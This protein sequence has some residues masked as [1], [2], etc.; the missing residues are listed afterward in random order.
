M[1]FNDHRQQLLRDLHLL[2]LIRNKIDK[3][4]LIIRVNFHLTGVIK[5]LI[6]AKTSKMKQQ[7]SFNN[8]YKS[9]K[10]LE[11]PIKMRSIMAESLSKKKNDFENF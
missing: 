9:S 11:T 1:K 6:Q 2:F 5:M 4:Q 8:S 10:I 3:C 7:L